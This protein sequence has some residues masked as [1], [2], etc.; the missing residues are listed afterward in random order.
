MT[1]PRD[2]LYARAM[3]GGASRPETHF[4]HPQRVRS[5]I[6]PNSLPGVPCRMTQL[7]QRKRISDTAL[8]RIRPASAVADLLQLRREYEGTP[9]FA[10]AVAE[11]KQSGVLIE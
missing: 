4:I 9:G 2:P 10:K 1:L 7:A 6:D 3:T 5:V 11:P 8:G